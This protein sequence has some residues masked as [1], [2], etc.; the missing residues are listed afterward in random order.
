MLFLV[1]IRNYTKEKN[2]LPL[3]DSKKKTMPDDSQRVYNKE[4]TQAFE[5]QKPLCS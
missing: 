3:T 1:S 5:T 4:N 2:I